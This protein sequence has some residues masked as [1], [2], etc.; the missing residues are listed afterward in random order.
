MAQDP[1]YAE[2]FRA[3]IQVAVGGL[4]SEAVRRAYEG[5]RKP[6]FYKG[7]HV[8]D[9]EGRLVYETEFSDNLLMFLLKAYDPKRFGDKL[10]A[11]FDANWSGNLEDLPEEF[12]RQFEEKLAARVPQGGYDFRT[13]SPGAV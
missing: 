5:V 4:E 13:V 6:V 7:E 9:S 10:R 2:R 11:T 1:G 8:R 12:L 3:S